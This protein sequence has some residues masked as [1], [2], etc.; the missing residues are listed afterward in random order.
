VLASIIRSIPSSG[1]RTIL[2]P[3]VTL[4]R[5]PLAAKFSTVRVEQCSFSATCRFVS[6]LPVLFSC[7]ACMTNNVLD[8]GVGSIDR[9]L[10]FYS[11][12]NSKRLPKSDGGC[13]RE[14]NGDKRNLFYPQ[15]PCS[16]WLYPLRTFCG[17]CSTR[18][19]D[20]LF[21]SA[22]ELLSP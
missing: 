22:F 20:A 9:R 21:E 17:L 7:S 3:R 18:F 11:E 12:Y 14:A 1:N 6:N 19:W 8:F 13:A 2:V 15:W 5:M 10:D 16:Y 4:G